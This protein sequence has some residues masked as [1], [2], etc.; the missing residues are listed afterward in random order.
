MKQS[1]RPSQNDEILPDIAFLECSTLD[2][3]TNGFKDIA[4]A[5]VCQGHLRSNF[6]FNDVSVIVTVTVEK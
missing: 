2:H 6:A 4:Y 1:C 5:L 3:A